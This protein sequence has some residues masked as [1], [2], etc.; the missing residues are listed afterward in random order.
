MF[1]IYLSRIKSNKWSKSSFT[2]TQILHSPLSHCYPNFSSS[3]NPPSS[4]FY[5]NLIS[6]SSQFYPNLI[7]PSCQFQP[8]LNFTPTQSY[9]HPNFTL[10]FV[11]KNPRFWL[12]RHLVF[13]LP[14]DRLPV[15]QIWTQLEPSHATESTPT[16]SCSSGQ[17]LHSAAA[18]FSTSKFPT[19]FPHPEDRCFIA[20]RISQ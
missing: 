18:R 12:N 1:G 19:G 13:L 9:P 6:P 4:L 17:R 3:L 10:T 16:G 11:Q 2:L 15:L 5:P 8:H 14:I 20:A 7:S